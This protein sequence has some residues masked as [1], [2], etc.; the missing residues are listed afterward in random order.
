[1]GFSTKAIH[2]GLTNDHQTGAVAFPIFQT[3]TF[4]QEVPG[5][6]RVFQNRGLS[7]ARSENPT[8]TALETTLAEL[9]GAEYC[10]ALSSGLAAVNNVLNLLKTGDHVIA[11]R[12]LYGGS[13]RLF[14]KLYEKFGIE[15]SFIDT[16]DLTNVVDA[17]CPETK[18]LWL[19]SPSNPLLNLVDISAASKIAKKHNILTLV[20]NTFATPYLQNPLD[21]GADIVLHSTTKYISG[22]SDV[23]NG[24][25]ITRNEDIWKELKFYQNSVGAIPGPQDCFLVLRGLKTLELRME[26]HCDNAFQIAEFLNSHE[27][28]KEVYYPGLKN[29]PGHEIAKRQQKKFGGIV[30]FEVKGELSDAQQLLRKLDLF[31]LAE[32]LGGVK[33]LICHPPS[34]THASVEREVRLE[35]GISDGLIRASAGIENV[36]DLIAD[37]ESGLNKVFEQDKEKQILFV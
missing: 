2:G 11:C 36:E 12:D 28:I 5:N 34:M 17:I 27:Q 16:T 26:R 22:H 7:Y 10:V 3:S 24:A 14:T 32:S 15:F 18:L 30:S 8:R 19:E 13:Y 35:A 20:D 25:V 33:S 1:M 31:T 9:E 29:H 6:P 37:L 21:L 4:S 23:I